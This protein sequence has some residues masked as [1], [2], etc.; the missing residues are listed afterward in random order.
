M[1]FSDMRA[2]FGNVHV[3]TGTHHALHAFFKC[4]LYF[5][6]LYFMLHHINLLPRLTQEIRLVGC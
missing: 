1:P 2:N 4:I 5:S 3:L 6:L